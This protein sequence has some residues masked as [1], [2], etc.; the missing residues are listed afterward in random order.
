MQQ[1]SIQLATKKLEKRFTIPE[2]ICHF[3]I[4]IPSKN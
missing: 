3:I 2:H 4:T 1:K